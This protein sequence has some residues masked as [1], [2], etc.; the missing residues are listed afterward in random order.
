MGQVLLCLRRG[1]GV[2]CAIGRC[3]YQRDLGLAA[4]L[5][6]ED[7]GFLQPAHGVGQGQESLVRP[8]RRLSVDGGEV[9]L[10]RVGRAKGYCLCE[11]CCSTEP[12]S[13]QY[14]YPN[15]CIRGAHL[16]FAAPPTPAPLLAMETVASSKLQAAAEAIEAPE[17]S[18]EETN[19][20]ETFM[21]DVCKG[22]NA[23]LWSD[24]RGIRV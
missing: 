9:E 20:K 5:D 4:V 18:S 14:T 24:A 1:L 22:G 23:E 17:S 16:S 12:G 15:K 6:G 8:L 3:A 13:R 19:P 10:Q 7:K 21:V 2:P 11:G